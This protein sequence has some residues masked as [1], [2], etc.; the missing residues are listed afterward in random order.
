MFGRPYISGRRILFSSFSFRLCMPVTSGASGDILTTV[1]PLTDGL[2][3]VWHSSKA[4]RLFG[5]Q[6]PVSEWGLQDFIGGAES[7]RVSLQTEFTGNEQWRLEDT[8]YYN[9][10][11][12]TSIWYR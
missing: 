11:N 2:S 6:C 9:E 5:L 3:A 7:F 8:A 12:L 10:N 1:A 4:S